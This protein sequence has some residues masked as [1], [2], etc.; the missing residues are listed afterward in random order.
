MPGVLR[1]RWRRPRRI[2]PERRQAPGSVGT[3]AAARLPEAAA[4]PAMTGLTAEQLARYRGCDPAN[5]CYPDCLASAQHSLANPIAASDPDELRNA[6]RWAARLDW[7]APSN[8]DTRHLEQGGP[9]SEAPAADGEDQ[10][11][12]VTH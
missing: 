2:L 4:A 12:P 11:G 1:P 6:A 8:P 9:D 10:A 7:P 5:G 3:R